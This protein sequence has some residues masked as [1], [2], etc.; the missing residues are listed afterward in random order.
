MLVSIN[1]T[2]FYRVTSKFGE[3]ESFRNKPH[4]GID[5]KMEIGEDVL[6]PADGVVEKIVDYGDENIGLGLRIRTE[7]D[8]TLILGHLDSV[9]VKEGDFVWSGRKIAESG[10]TGNTTGPHLHIGLKNEEGQFEDPQDYVDIFQ[11]LS[12]NHVLS[13]ADGHA[14][15][16]FDDV[17]EF[18]V[19]KLLAASGLTLDILKLIGFDLSFGLNVLF[20]MVPALLCIYARFWLQIKFAGRWILP[21]LYSYFVID[22]LQ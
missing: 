19:D 18:V 21:L 1:K 8:E 10:N 5:L 14:P 12:R 9:S 2:P 20:F 17:K 15:P 22:L 13:N 6:S 11:N 16:L 4:S 3:M 7:D